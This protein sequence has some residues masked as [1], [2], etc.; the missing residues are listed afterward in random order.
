MAL[1][2]DPM[3][4]QNEIAQFEEIIGGDMV[5]YYEGNYRKKMAQA[6]SRFYSAV[7]EQQLSHSGDNDLFQ[8]LIN[9]VPKETPQGTLVTKANRNSP[10][11]IDLAI[12]AIMAFDRWSDMTLEPEEEV[13]EDPK[14][15]NL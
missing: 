9:C 5:L 15:I 10:H 7:L 14:F 11:K 12:G 2:V 8:H 4:W 6:C 3:G 1:T 13:K